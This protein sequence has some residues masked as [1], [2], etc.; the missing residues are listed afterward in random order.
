MPL[1]CFVV[2]QETEEKESELFASL[3]LTC[4]PVLELEFHPTVLMRER[5][6]MI[7]F[8]NQNNWSN[9][10]LIHIIMTVFGKYNI[11]IQIL[12]SFAMLRSNMTI[13]FHPIPN[14][15]ILHYSS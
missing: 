8:F 15:L 3:E 11:C 6:I 2:K 12:D 5:M 7:A 14:N 1:V 10:K 4:D 9:N 13:S